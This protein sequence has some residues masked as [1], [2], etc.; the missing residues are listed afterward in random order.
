MSVRAGVIKGAIFFRNL[1]VIWSGPLA[2]LKGG[3]FWL[4]RSFFTPFS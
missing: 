3:G 2:L 1:G 4:S